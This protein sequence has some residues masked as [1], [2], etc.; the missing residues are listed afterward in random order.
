MAL[1]RVGTIVAIHPIFH[2][3]LVQNRSHGNELNKFCPLN[4]SNDLYLFFCIYPTSLEEMWL[5]SSDS[6]EEM[7]LLSSGS[8]EE[9]WWLSSG[10]LE[11]M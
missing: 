6:I 11:E 2:I 1:G 10:S 4:I 7:W 9:M 3:F 5:L 8:I